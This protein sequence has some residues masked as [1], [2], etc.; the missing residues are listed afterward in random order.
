MSP[1]TNNI[2]KFLLCILIAIVSLLAIDEMR[3][4]CAYYSHRKALENG[5]LINYGIGSEDSIL[6]Y[7]YWRITGQTYRKSH[8]L[9]KADSVQ[10]DCTYQELINYSLRRSLLR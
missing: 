6:E 3:A 9:G 4:T 10:A 1:E 8:S 7:V 5:I 2:K